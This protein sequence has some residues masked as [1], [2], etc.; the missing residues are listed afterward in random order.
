MAHN[1]CGNIFKHF[2]LLFGKRYNW[3]NHYRFAGM[4]SKRVEILH[5]YNGEAM[6]VCITYHFEFN[7]FPAFQR[8][9]YKYLL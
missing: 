2:N 4:D 8:L 3:G 1:A 6:V 9:L 7:F 5:R